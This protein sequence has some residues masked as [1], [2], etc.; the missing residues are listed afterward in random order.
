MAIKL[1]SQPSKKISHSIL[2]YSRGAVSAFRFF[3]EEDFLHMMFDM[4]LEDINADMKRFEELEEFEICRK[5]KFVIREKQRIE[6]L[7]LRVLI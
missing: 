6:A 7:S 1:D 4:S 5:L 3:S 2:A